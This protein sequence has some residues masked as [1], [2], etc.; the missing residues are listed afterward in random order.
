MSILFRA[1]LLI[2][3]SCVVHSF[4]A[5]ARADYILNGAEFATYRIRDDG[6]PAGGYVPPP[7]PRSMVETFG[8]DY[9]VTPDFKT[10]YQFTNSLG[11]SDL[12]FAYDVASG[13]YL[14]DKLCTVVLSLFHPAMTISSSTHGCR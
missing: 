8:E 10:V 2:A 11:H 4:T 14:P 12:I 7:G 13:A 5:V 1:A 6:T 9:A 3:A